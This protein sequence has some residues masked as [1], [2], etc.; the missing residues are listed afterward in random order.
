M[1][2]EMMKKLDKLDLIEERV[3]SFEQDLKAV[4]D[5]IEFAHAEVNDLKVDNEARKKMDE[6]TR[7]RLEK[8]ENKNTLL[9]KSLIYLQ[10]RSM[11]DN[12][13][14]YNIPET[15]G[16]ETTPIIHKLL[17]ENMGIKDATKNIKIDGSHR[18]GRP[19]PGERKPRPIVAKFNYHQ[20]RENIRRNA[21]KLEGTNIGIVEQFPAQIVK[22]WKELYPE[23]MKAKRA[24][25]KAKLMRD[26]LIIDSQV[27]KP[28]G[29]H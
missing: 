23:L 10:A 19:K 6:Y 29:Q 14:F 16:E 28:A 2:T 15:K 21:M 22:V 5:S 25:K 11:R 18:L 8:L 24:R 26:K 1:M 13:I 17:E 12:L 3:K 20:D 4:K 7:Q 9:S 27:F